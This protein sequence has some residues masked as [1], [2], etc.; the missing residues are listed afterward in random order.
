MRDIDGG[1]WSSGLQ[2]A[3]ILEH[4]SLCAAHLHN[5]QPV[6]RANFMLHTVE[7]IFYGLL[8]KAKVIRDFFIRQ[9]LRDQRN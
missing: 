4:E 7:V 2:I 6:F 8:G 1:L 3:R 5:A 9:S